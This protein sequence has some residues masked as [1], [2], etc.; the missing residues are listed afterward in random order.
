MLVAGDAA[1]SVM[2]GVGAT[3]DFIG[4]AFHGMATSHL[5]ALC[6]VAVDGRIYNGFPVSEVRSTGARRSSV[7]VIAEAS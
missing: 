4:V 5:D 7:M 6:H 2:P 3:M 1:D